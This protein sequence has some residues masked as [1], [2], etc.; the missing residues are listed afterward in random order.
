M[1]ASHSDLVK[2]KN[3]NQLP[4][5]VILRVFSSLHY[6]DLTSARATSRRWRAL[7]RDDLL[8]QRLGQRDLKGG[9]D[10]HSDE[11]MY[12]AS[13]LGTKLQQYLLE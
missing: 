11:E 2:V 9:H 7:S 10:L 3:I 6:R 1:T 13:S 8:L 12:L 5:E 4:K